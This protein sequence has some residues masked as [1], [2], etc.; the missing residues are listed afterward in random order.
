MAH[1]EEN[2]EIKV[3]DKGYVK[4]I[5]SM[6]SDEEIVAAARMST[7]GA[8]RGWDKDAS[9][10][11]YLYEMGHVS[12]FEQCALS[13]EFQ[14]PLFVVA[15][16]VRHRTFSFNILSSRYT[17]M[18]DLFYVPSKER[19]KDRQSKTD[20]Q[21][22]VPDI[23][24]EP[25]SAFLELHLKTQFDHN[26]K[27]YRRYLE[28]GV[29]RELSR[30]ALPVA[31]YTR[32][33]MSGNLRNWFH[34]LSLR[35]DSHAQWETR[36]YAE[37]IYSVVAKLFPR[38]T[39]LFRDDLYGARLSHNELTAIVQMFAATYGDCK[40]TYRNVL[41]QRGYSEKKADRAVKRLFGETS[42]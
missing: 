35:L 24:N 15:Q 5:G 8:F 12:P 19:L 2:Q 6:G 1:N 21:G 7:D 31:Q 37:A 32:V 22:S 40:T 23:M 28:H 3:L 11:D 36:Q 29:P 33:R 27:T 41:T 34:F 13:I 16:I 42:H 30:I 4:L 9:F 20:K 10:L 25:H 14:A 26:A 39:E 17:E 38:S 18:P